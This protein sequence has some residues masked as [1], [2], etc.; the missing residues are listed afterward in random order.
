MN[1]GDVDKG[2]V[3]VH[4]DATGVEDAG[5][6]LLLVYISTWSSEKMGMVSEGG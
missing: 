4:C 1:V 6:A 5:D 2:N 3:L